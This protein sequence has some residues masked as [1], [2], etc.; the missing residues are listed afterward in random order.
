MNIFQL[1]SQNY[2]KHFN[3]F[4]LIMIFETMILITMIIIAMIIITRILIKM[5]FIAMIFMTMIFITTI[6]HNN[7]IYYND[8]CRYAQDY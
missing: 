7:D 8:T 6:N 5:I 3:S 1:T 2:L 4:I